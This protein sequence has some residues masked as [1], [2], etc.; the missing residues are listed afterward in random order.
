[1]RDDQIRDLLRTLDDDR[2]PDSA[3]AEALYGRLA[4]LRQSRQPSRT[5]VVL[6]AAT[7]LVVLAAGAVIGS[8]WPR[9]P[10]MVEASPDASPA[11][12]ATLSQ[13]TASPSTGPELTGLILAVTAPELSLRSEP[14]TTADELRVLRAGQRMRVLAGPMVA[15]GMDWYEIRI[16][17]GDVTGWVA[18]GP[19]RD[20]LA[21]V[22]DGA[23][24]GLCDVPECPEG[25][26]Y[27]LATVDGELGPR[28]GGE[29]VSLWAWSPDGS[30]VALTLGPGGAVNRVIVVNADG[31]GAH[32]VSADGEPPHWSPDGTRLAWSTGDALWVTDADL[33]PHE[34]LRMEPRIGSPVWSPDGS[35][36]A[37]GQ[38][39]CPGCPEGYGGPDETGSLWTVG[40][41]G[42]DLR[43]VPDSTLGAISGWAPDGS[44]LSVGFGGAV[45]D[46]PPGTYLVSVADGAR[47]RVFGD[48]DRIGWA[49]WSP[50][51]T[52]LAADSE[53]GIWIADGEG[54]NPRLLVPTTTDGGWFAEPRWAPSGRRL[55]YWAILSDG[56]VIRF[57]DVT[58]GEVRDIVTDV[59]TLRPMQWQ[60]VLVPL[61]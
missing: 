58:T 22:E 5:T 6:L 42:S 47:T 31:S 41:D 56:P 13:S 2:A 9:P 21:S 14:G 23:I 7:L 28:I 44:R 3:F 55:L 51:G 18:A 10:V 16:G 37:F 30:R 57:A 17:P 33:V 38:R 53:D 29:E 50:D 61:P 12:S 1:M 20:W 4:A 45:G 15:D 26:G 35:R 32:E 52:T 46:P 49:I 25:R 27:Y 24:A 54:S 60:P 39:L 34:V 8:G 43:R 40:V 48:A 19:G 36:I 59:P 11:P